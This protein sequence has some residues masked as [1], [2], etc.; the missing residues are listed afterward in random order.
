MQLVTTKL[1]PYAYA[2]SVH[3]TRIIHIWNSNKGVLQFVVRW[4]PSHTWNSV[5]KACRHSG[6]GRYI[7]GVIPTQYVCSPLQSKSHGRGVGGC[8]SHFYPW[9]RNTRF[10]YAPCS[11]PFGLIFTFP[12]HYATCAT[13]VTGY[14]R[15]V[16]T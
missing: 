14:S 2:K 3:R 8:T 5:V 6:Y 16:R 11:W 15:G 13:L 12:L 9:T 7:N 4:M 1:K 10:H